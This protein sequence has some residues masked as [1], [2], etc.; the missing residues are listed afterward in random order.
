M[1]LVIN[2]SKNVAPVLPAALS[3]LSMKSAKFTP[4]HEEGVRCFQFNLFL[5]GVK[6]GL[7][8]EN[9]FTVTISIDFCNQKSKEA[10]DEFAQQPDVIEHVKKALNTEEFD[11]ECLLI[12][13]HSAFRD[14]FSYEDKQKRNKKKHLTHLEFKSGKQFFTYSWPKRQLTGIPADALQKAIKKII[15]EDASVGL[16]T[17]F[18]NTPEQ[19][20]TLGI[21]FTEAEV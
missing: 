13:I 15:D 17:E 21:Q 3:A 20:R 8:E 14:I 1:S 9:D 4:S 11:H 19:F 16:V 2:F 18:L 7:V 12:E 5:G 6:V 10:F